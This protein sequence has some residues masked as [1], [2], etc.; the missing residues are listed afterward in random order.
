[1]FK[2][3]G[4]LILIA[5]MLCFFTAGCDMLDDI[6]SNVPDS[7]QAAENSEDAEMAAG[8][9]SPIVSA[10]TDELDYSSGWWG[11]FATDG[12]HF[13]ISDVREKSFYFEYSNLYTEQ[14][15]DGTADL[16]YNRATF[17]NLELWLEGDVLTVFWAMPPEDSNADNA[18]DTA[19]DEEPADTSVEYW[20]AFSYEEIDSRPL[21]DDED[22]VLQADALAQ[23]DSAFPRK[24]EEGVFLDAVG[25]VAINGQ[26]CWAFAM[27][28]KF[29]KGFTGTVHYAVSNDGD[30]FVR[31]DYL[32]MY[33]IQ[34]YTKFEFE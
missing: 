12:S 16:S 20:R 30:V 4:I 23:L 15:I 27:M 11:T 5:A 24:T 8:D 26:P 6:L 14:Y 19:A 28:N 29:E 2:R 22:M 25:A 3:F 33:V 31:N 32:S 34:P 17:S 13:V 10:D 7:Q 1:M 21:E 9:D 18:A